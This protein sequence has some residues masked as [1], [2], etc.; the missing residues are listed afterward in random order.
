MC[1]GD[2]CVRFCRLKFEL[3]LQLNRCEFDTFMCFMIFFYESIPYVICIGYIGQAFLGY[4]C[5]FRYFSLCS[6][7]VSLK[8]LNIETFFCQIVLMMI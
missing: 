1:F 6:K 4:C 8:K 2:W 5:N 3:V 7:K